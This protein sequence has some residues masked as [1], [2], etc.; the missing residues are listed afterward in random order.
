MDSCSA[1]VCVDLKVA[2]VI[3]TV[4]NFSFFFIVSS[5]F[6]LKLQ[7]NFSLGLRNQNAL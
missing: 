5:L 7:V 3:R 6:F 1:S 4:D 2:E